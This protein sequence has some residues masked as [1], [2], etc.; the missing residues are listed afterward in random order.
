MDLS[1]LLV[2]TAVLAVQTHRSLVATAAA[3][4]PLPV[5]MAC[6]TILPLAVP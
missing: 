5:C 2:A 4:T 3:L 6:T 1:A